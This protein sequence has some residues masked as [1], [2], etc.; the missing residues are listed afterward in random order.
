[1][2]GCMTSRGIGCMCKIEG[3]IIQASYLRIL[4]DGVMQTIE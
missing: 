4:R 2:R 1:M 3:K